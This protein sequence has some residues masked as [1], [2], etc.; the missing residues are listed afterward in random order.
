[1]NPRATLLRFSLSDS[2]PPGPSSSCEPFGVPTLDSLDAGDAAEYAAWAD[3]LKSSAA[4]VYDAEAHAE[5]LRDSG[6]P[7]AAGTVGPYF[8]RFPSEDSREQWFNP[9]VVASAPCEPVDAPVCEQVIPP[10]VIVDTID[11]D[12]APWMLRA[13]GASEGDADDAGDITDALMMRA[14]DCA[15][16]A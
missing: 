3:S 7:D 15:G 4:E 2:F 13:I 12:L 14:H 6:E 8:D 16:R 9:C 5:N 11:R 1:M 10:A